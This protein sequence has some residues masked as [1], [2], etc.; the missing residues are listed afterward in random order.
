MRSMLACGAHWPMSERASR[1]LM[2]AGQSPTAIHNNCSGKHAGMLATAVHLG[3][4]RAATSGLDHPR[5]RRDQA[6]HFRDLRR[7]HWSRT[8]WASMAARCRRS[9]FR[10]RRSLPV[11]RGL[12]AAGDLPRPRPKRREG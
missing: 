4:D 3:L 9:R 6:S 8:R 12:R 5:A 7:R 1:E 10:S 11:L 2:R